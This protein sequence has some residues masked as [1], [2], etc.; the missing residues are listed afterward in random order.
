MNYCSS[1]TELIHLKISDGFIRPSPMKLSSLIPLL[2]AIP[3][4]V[5][6]LTE[7]QTLTAGFDSTV[8]YLAGNGVVTTSTVPETSEWQASY[9]LALDPVV[10]P[11]ATFPLATAVNLSNPH[12]AMADA[13]GN[14]FI[15]DKASNCIL[16]VTPDGR[17]RRFAGTNYPAIYTSPAYTETLP[18]HQPGPYY[19]PDH[20]ITTDVPGPATSINLIGCNGLCVLPNGVVYI[21]D[22]GNHRIRKVALNGTMTTVVNDLDPLWLPS[23]RGLWVSPSEDLIYYTQEVADLSQ[24]VPIGV[25]VNRPPLGG[26]V[27]KW[28]PTG[29][30]QAVTRYPTAPTRALLEFTNPGNIDVNPITHKLYVTDRAEDAP[31]NSCVWRIDT[32]SL[33]PPALTSTKTRVAGIGAAAT[34]TPDSTDTGTLLAKDATLN[35]VRGI[36]FTPNG[37]YFLCTHRGGKVWYVDSDANYTTAKIHLFLLGRGKNDVTYFGPTPLALPVTGIECHSQPRQITVAP[38]GSLLVVSN[39]S[40]LV[41]KIKYHVIPSAPSLRQVVTTIPNHF[42]FT[43]D[44]TAGQSYIVERSPSLQ[45]GSWQAIDVVTAG[46]ATAEYFDDMASGGAREFYR[47]VPPR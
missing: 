30:I 33:N 3:G 11:T 28:T 24:P 39:D 41:R 13:F 15:G 12:I 35:Q 6:A 10:N 9:D 40:G 25:S 38:D 23:G 27:K 44:S 45:S 21:Y 1:V 19:P 36:A 2:A 16:K 31:A 29:G 46:S 14:V 17:I 5:S 37:G 47:L 32:D 18:Y 8:G 20:V 7:F 43:W 42:H 26:V 4:C 34:S 22:A